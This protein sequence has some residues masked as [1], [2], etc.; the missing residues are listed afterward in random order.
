MEEKEKKLMATE[1]TRISNYFGL[2]CPLK[3]A[4]LMEES[5]DSELDVEFTTPSAVVKHPECC[6]PDVV[7]VE[8][9]YD[10]KDFQLNKRVTTATGYKLK[11][12]EK[13]LKKAPPK[14]KLDKKKSEVRVPEK[15]RPPTAKTLPKK[16]EKPAAPSKTLPKKTDSKVPPKKEER[17]SSV[18]APTKKE[19]KPAP[20]KR[21]STK[22]PTVK[23]AK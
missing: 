1:M 20:A 9:Q 2:K 7:G 22:K 23:P 18:K 11:L 19:E 5:S 13:K 10:I 4:N 14:E 8:T 3:V 15:E 16:E 17:P 12:A 21:M 6:K